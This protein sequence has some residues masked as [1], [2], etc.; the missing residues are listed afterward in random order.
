MTHAKDRT[1]EVS[2]RSITSASAEILASQRFEEVG[3]VGR[4]LAEK[5]FVERRWLALHEHRVHQVVRLEVSAGSVPVSGVAERDQAA[6]SEQAYR[7][8]VTSDDISVTGNS[9]TGLFYGV[10]TLVQL[11]KLQGGVFASEPP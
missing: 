9:R 11:L 3:A 10:Q 2:D 7:L 6:I 4:L 1:P 5:G 8:R